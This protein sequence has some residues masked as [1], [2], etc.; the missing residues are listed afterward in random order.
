[1]WAEMTKMQSMLMLVLAVLLLLPLASDA[2]VKTPAPTT[3]KK[4]ERQYS[5]Q[6]KRGE[7]VCGG[8]YRQRR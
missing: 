6:Y 3:T 4:L 7:S 8:K 2:Q 1:M 5:R